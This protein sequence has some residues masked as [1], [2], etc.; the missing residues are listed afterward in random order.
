[1][2]C[3]IR[4]E[5][6]F[7]FAFET[8]TGGRKESKCYYIEFPSNVYTNLIY[9]SEHHRVLCS[10]IA[11]Y[12]IRG[13]D[14]EEKIEIVHDEED[15]DRIPLSFSIELGNR[16]EVYSVLKGITEEELIRS[17]IVYWIKRRDENNKRYWII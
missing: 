11:E 8:L 15:S 2:N 5:S 4:E 7:Y 10:D 13:I 14:L 9:Y 3:N 6:A 16:L 1:M 17:S 12:M